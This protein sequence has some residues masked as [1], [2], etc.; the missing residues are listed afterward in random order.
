[1]ANS[2]NPK[3]ATPI[4]RYDGAVWNDSARVYYIPAA[5]TNAIAVGDFVT[6][7]HALA[8]TGGINAIDLTATGDGNP[9]TGV[10]VGFAGSCKAGAGVFLSSFWPLTTS[11]GQASRPATT[12][13]DYYVYV[14]DDPEI[15]CIIQE[16]DNSGGTPGT[17]LPVTAVGLNANFVYAAPSVYGVSKTQLG[18]NT[19]GTGAT[20]QLSI[21]GFLQDYGLNVAGATFAKVIVTINNHTEAPN[22]AGI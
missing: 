16:D 14:N 13:L 3:G 21:K 11:G 8:D 1:M 15:Q 17:P 19:T 22:K 12:A 2:N 20:K 7:S 9:I 10:V 18:A 5:V 4:A 6:K